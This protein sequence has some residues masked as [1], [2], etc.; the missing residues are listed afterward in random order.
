MPDK[1]KSDLAPP[2]PKR[3]KMSYDDDEGEDWSSPSPH[4]RPRNNPTYG[5]KNAF[6]GLDDGGDQLFYGPAEDGLEYL[7][8]VRY[9]YLL[10]PSH[11]F[12]IHPCSARH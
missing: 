11:H 12:P 2:S 8:M 3:A 9:A 6:P 4:E 1:R 7:R 10:I 5:Q